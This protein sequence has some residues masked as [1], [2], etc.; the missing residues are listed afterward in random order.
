MFDTDVWRS[1]PH[2]LLILA[3]RHLQLLQSALQALDLHTVDLHL[4]QLRIGHPL[5]QFKAENRPVK[6]L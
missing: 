6:Q 5:N 3:Q 1:A 4:R 2:L